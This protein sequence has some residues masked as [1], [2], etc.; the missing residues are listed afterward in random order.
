MG[1]KLAWILKEKW[2]WI[3]ISFLVLIL[4]VP[5]VV[6]YLILSLP[7]MWSL[8]A[9]VLLLI[10]W[11]VVAGYKDWIIAKR[12]EAEKTKRNESEG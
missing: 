10:V 6:I 5:Y 4:T 12:E 11:S 3:I 1:Q 8:V 9:T 7:P 2:L